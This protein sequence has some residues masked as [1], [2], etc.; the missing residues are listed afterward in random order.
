MGLIKSPSELETKKTISMLIYGEPGIG[1]TTLGCSAPNAVLFDYDGGVQRIN[2]AHRV[3]TVQIHSWAETNEALNEIANDRSIKCDSIVI[4]T[5]GK[6]LDYMSAYIIAND[7]RMAQKDGSLSLKGYGVRKTMFIDFIKRVSVMGKN[8]IFIAHEREDKRGEETIKRPEIGG[9]S[10][11]DLI[12]E[13]DLVGY[14]HAVGKVRCI[15]FDP[16]EHHYGKNTCNL[17]GTNQE[18]KPISDIGIVANVD[19]NGN[20]AGANNFLCSIIAQYEQAQERNKEVCASY[21][22]QVARLKNQ[23]AH[24]NSADDAN[25]FIE[26]M[27]GEQ[28][29]FNAKLIISSALQAR[30]A[31]LGLVFN[32]E[33]K[34]YVAA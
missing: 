8:I 23:V 21:E 2:V 20:A 14:M 27:R 32:K 17:H 18:G 4:D 7:P 12:K 6:M 10:A 5:A 24:I 30:C 3:P 1:K 15:N 9:S 26:N 34:S 29:I 25:M 33:S 31:E 19:A 22:E 28:F 11:N 13:L 16:E